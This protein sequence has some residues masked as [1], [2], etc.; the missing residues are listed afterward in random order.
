M[1]QMSNAYLWVKVLH[2]LAVISWMAGMLYLPRLFVYHAGSVPGSAQAA[3]FAV[4]ERRLMRVIMLPAML[5][6]WATGLALAT[7]GGFFAAGWL[8]GKLALVLALS[9]LHGYFSKLRKNFAE[10]KN[11]RETR[12][13]RMINEVPALLM[14]GIV[15]LVVF[16]PV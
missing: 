16:K 10:D 8:H 9:V 5:V 2:I 13:F 15:V 4:M 6:T 11:R 7:Q 3:T 1:H 14:A 12:F